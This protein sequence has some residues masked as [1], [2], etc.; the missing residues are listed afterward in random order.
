MCIF[1]FYVNCP[2]KNVHF[3]HL[4]DSKKPGALQFVMPEACDFESLVIESFQP[5]G[6]DD[7]DDGNHLITLKNILMGNNLDPQALVWRPHVPS[8]LSTFGIYCVEPAVC[9]L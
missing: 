3:K 1:D 4:F 2:F 7:A 8:P 9:W 6:D 5:Q